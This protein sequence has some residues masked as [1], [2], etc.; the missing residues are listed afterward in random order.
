MPTLTISID[1][2]LLQATQ[3]YVAEHK[4]TLE[5][6]I[7]DYL[8]QLIQTSPVSSWTTG[9]NDTVS[10]TIASILSTSTLKFKEEIELPVNPPTTTIEEPLMLSSQQV[11]QQMAEMFSKLLK[12]KHQ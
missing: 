6:L 11:Q 3:Q 2:A 10:S 1:E 8:T 7:H 5:Q 12:P 4:T 9:E